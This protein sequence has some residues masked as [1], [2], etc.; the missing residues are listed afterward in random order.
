MDNSLL[1]FDDDSPLFVNKKTKPK[2]K[3]RKKKPSVKVEIDIIE[4]DVPKRKSKKKV[5]K[6]ANKYIPRYTIKSPADCKHILPV[7][8]DKLNAAWDRLNGDNMVAADVANYIRGVAN[9]AKNSRPKEYEEL[10]V[11]MKYVKEL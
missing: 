3:P 9:V 5:E 6:V 4:D 11:L 2:R 1:T 7:F 10:R 8:K